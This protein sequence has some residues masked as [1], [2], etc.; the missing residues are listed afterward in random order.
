MEI[1]IYGLG[2]MGAN[3]V[4]RLHQS[5]EHRVLA[6]NRSGGKVDEIRKE[7]IEG[8]YSMEEM[9][10]AL[11]KPRAIWVMVPAG[12][13]TSDALSAFADLMDEGD[14]LIDGGNS[15]FRDSVHH[16]KVLSEKGIR[17][18]D[19][20]TSGGIWGLRVGY[21]LMV[22]GDASAFE[23][24]EPALRTLAPEEG[25]AYL[26]EAG[27]GHFTKMVHNGIEYG[28]MQ[29][30]AEGFEILEKSRYDYD[31]RTVSNLWNQGS[32]V[33]SW[34]LELAHEAFVKDAKLDSIRGYVEDSGEGRWTVI[35]AIEEDVPANTIAGSLF[36]RFAS[37]QEDSFAMKV[38]AA[39]RGGF[40]GHAIKEAAT[41]DE[42]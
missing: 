14:I 38:I 39:L 36:A 10:Q 20:G 21:C 17:F 18:L 3:M 37:R 5:G 11:E 6:G 8:V 23:H 15:Y 41:E 26:G 33:R 12:E 9:V 4:R 27:A 31:L 19:A 16:A 25:Y 7:G 40:G 22:G 29:A 35:E 1:G 24:V 30:Y 13:A 42:K 34:L 2:R 28:M 32:V